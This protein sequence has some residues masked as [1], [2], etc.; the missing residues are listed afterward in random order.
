VLRSETFCTRRPCVTA[1]ATCCS[2]NTCQDF[3]LR[4]WRSFPFN[5]HPG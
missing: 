3:S 4:S 1:E 5:F 2:A